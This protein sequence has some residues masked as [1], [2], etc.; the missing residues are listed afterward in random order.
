VTLDRKVALFAELDDTELEKLEAIAEE[1]SY[2]S[3]DIILKQGSPADAVYIVSQGAVRVT[4]IMADEDDA[5]G[6][7]EEVLVRLGPGE[8]FGELSFVSGSVPSLSVIADQETRA[9]T[10]P[11]KALG[12]LLDSDGALCRKLLFAMMRTMVDRLRETDRELVLSRYFI[13][14]R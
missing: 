7:D 5:V 4:A 12:E 3:G 11:H 14:G 13:R 10:L 9:L 8:F 6:R 1:R 2:Y